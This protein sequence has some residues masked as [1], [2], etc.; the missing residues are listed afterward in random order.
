MDKKVL[1]CMILG[2]IE[3]LIKWKGYAEL[4]NTWEPAEN[5]QCF[6][7]IAE[8]EERYKSEPT[9]YHSKY[10]KSSAKVKQNLLCNTY[11]IFLQDEDGFDK[12]WTCRRIIGASQ[13]EEG[14]ILFL[15]QW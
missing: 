8:F 3:Y 11:V 12:S 1:N 7:M 15:V 10:K 2:K 6:G 14:D 13:D 9:F 5:L 4:E